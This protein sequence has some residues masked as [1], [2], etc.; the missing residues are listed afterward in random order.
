MK[1]ISSPFDA[2]FICPLPTATSYFSC[3]LEV[4][5]F[6]LSS[7]EA[8]I[9]CVRPPLLNLLCETCSFT[10]NGEVSVKCSSCLLLF[11]HARE[12]TASSMWSVA[13]KRLKRAACECLHFQQK[14][15]FNIVLEVFKVSSSQANFN[16]FSCSRQ[17]KCS[18]LV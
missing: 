16:L 6:H 5:L 13:K 7:S 11:T 8:A 4:Q 2:R 10:R 9:I 3:L 12:Q 18:R 15:F 17:G 14:G 1:V